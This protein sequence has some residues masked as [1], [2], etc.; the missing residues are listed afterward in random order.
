MAGGRRISAAQ[1]SG[2]RP[3]ARATARDGRAAVG[4]VEVLSVCAAEGGRLLV[5]SARRPAAAEGGGR[6]GCER[7]GSGRMA[8]GMTLGGGMRV[9]EEGAGRFRAAGRG[10]GGGARVGGGDGAET[11]FGAVG[12]VGELEVE[13]A[14]SSGICSDGGVFGLAVAALPVWAGSEG[15]LRESGSDGTASVDTDSLRSFALCS[16]RSRCV[17]TSPFGFSPSP[18]GTATCS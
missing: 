14:P 10:D 5:G 7:R 18:V 6:A 9:F 13:D 3:G 11:A 17:L 12:V 15:A 8:E 4:S 1:S 16:G 2:E